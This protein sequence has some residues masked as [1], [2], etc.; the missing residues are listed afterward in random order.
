M[1]LLGKKKKVLVVKVPSGCTD[2]L[3]PL[4]LS[5]NKPCKSF[6]RGKISTWYS[7]EVAKQLSSGV[8]AKEVKVDTRMQVVKELS[9]QWLAGFYDQMQNK[10][11]IHCCSC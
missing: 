11:E 1:K 2:E 4:D 10:L 9:A 6:L 5:V 3:Q 7:Q 8:Q